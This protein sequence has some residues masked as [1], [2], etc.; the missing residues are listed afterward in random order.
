MNRSVGRAFHVLGAMGCLVLE[1]CSRFEAT[2]NDEIVGSLKKIVTN[3]I[4]D[5]FGIN[6]NV[7]VALENPT[8]PGVVCSGTLGKE[9]CAGGRVASGAVDRE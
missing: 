1:A 8:R 3:G 4:I 7:V 6:A 9:L 2:S 5:H